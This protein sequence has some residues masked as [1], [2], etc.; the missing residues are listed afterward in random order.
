MQ[1]FIGTLLG[2]LPAPYVYGA[3]ED[4]FDDGGKKSY[5]LNMIVLF[6]AVILLGYSRKMKFNM[7]YGE[8]KNEK[9]NDIDLDDNGSKL[10]NIEENGKPFEEVP[11]K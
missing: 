4:F 2:Y 11:I 6:L 1:L 9:I 5:F 7:I 10:I 8:N 3:L